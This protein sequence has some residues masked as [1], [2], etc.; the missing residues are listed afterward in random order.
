MNDL[1]NRASKAMSS[2]SSSKKNTM[3]QDPEPTSSA[4]STPPPTPTGIPAYPAPAPPTPTVTAQSSA[5]IKRIEKMLVAFAEK[6]EKSAP[7]WL[8]PV[9]KAVPSIVMQVSE[10]WQIVVAKR[11]VR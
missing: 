9:L 3:T 2:P 8:Q 11:A 4:P 6:G 1:F 7:T 5:E 10:R